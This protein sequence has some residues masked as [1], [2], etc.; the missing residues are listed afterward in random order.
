MCS[1][2]GWTEIGTVVER[3]EWKKSMLTSVF[4]W[5]LS[6]TEERLDEVQPSARSGR[7]GSGR[8]TYTKRTRRM[9]RSMCLAL[10]ENLFS[11]SSALVGGLYAENSGHVTDWRGSR[12][13]PE[14]LS[15]F[16]LAWS[17]TYAV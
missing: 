12:T 13:Q 5:P 10:G 16:P 11:S 8:T 1:P 3:V 4:F 17:G 9:G 15:S 2:P 7:V 6:L 14:M